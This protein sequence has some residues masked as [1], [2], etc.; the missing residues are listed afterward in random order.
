MIFDITAD[1]IARL[2]EYQLP[3]LLRILLVLECQRFKIP[4]SAVNVACSIKTPDGGVDGSVHW[5]GLPEKT[6]YLPHKYVVFQCK[7]QN[8]TSTQAGLEVEKHDHEG[9]KPEVDAALNEGAAYILFTKT[10]LTDQQ[11]KRKAIESIRNTF[12]RYE[13]SYKDTYIDVFDAAQI[14]TWT[15]QHFSAILTVREWIGR[16]PIDGFLPFQEWKKRRECCRR[17]SDFMIDSSLEK[18]MEE[19]AKR[20]ISPGESTRIVGLSGLGKTETV[21]QT[22]NRNLSNEYHY[23]L[24]YVDAAEVGAN[25]L[26]SRVRTLIGKNRGEWFGLIVDNCEPELHSRLHEI[27]SQSEG[28]LITI[29]TT[30]EKR[31]CDNTIIFPYASDEIIKQIITNRHPS[32]NSES[33]LRIVKFADGFPLIAVI[34]GEDIEKGTHDIGNLRDDNL[35]DKLLGN[36]TDEHKRSLQ[37]CAL[38]DCFGFSGDQAGQAKYIASEILSP[39]IAYE[40]FYRHIKDYE[41]RRL[42]DKRGDYRRVIPRPLAVSLAT[43]WWQRTSPG[44]IKEVIELLSTPEASTRL[45]EAFCRAMPQISFVKEA[46]DL[47]ETLCISPGPLSKKEGFESEWGSRL[48]LAFVEINPDATVDAIYSVTQKLTLEEIKK[49]ITF[50][51]RRNLV[52]ALEKLCFRKDCFEKAAWVLLRF[53]AAENENYANN[54]TGLFCQLFQV[55]LS[56]TETPPERR[57]AVI[58]RALREKDIRIKRIVIQAL[59]QVFEVDVSRGSGHE[60]Q[61]AS[62]ELIDWIPKLWGEIFSYYEKS[63]DYLVKIILEEPELAALAK[64]QIARNIRNILYYR[65]WDMLDKVLKRVIDHSGNYWP[66]ALS[67]IKKIKQFKAEE[68]PQ[69]MHDVLEEWESLLIP[70][71]LRQRIQSYVC[72]PPYENKK[73]PNGGYINIASINAEKFA[74]ECVV[75]KDE[76]IKDL[77]LLVQG[78]IRQGFVFGR[79]LALLLDDYHSI[80]NLLINEL[81]RVKPTEVNTSFIEGVLNG[82]QT[83]SMEDWK[84]YTDSIASNEKLAPFYVKIIHKSKFTH[85]QL[86]VIL[87]LFKIGKLSLINI[88]LLGCGKVLDQIESKYVAEFCLN[89][90]DISLEGKW[91]ALYLL[92]MFCFGNQDH[93]EDCE[94]SF[95][96]ILLEL[97]LNV[98]PEWFS[99]TDVWSS[100][101]NKLLGKNDNV[102]AEVLVK[103]IFDLCYNTHGEELS[104]QNCDVQL[105]LSTLVKCEYYKEILKHITE[106]LQS[107][108]SIA[109]LRLDFL[110]TSSRN[111]GQDRHLLMQFPKELLLKWANDNLDFAPEY[112]AKA[113][114]LYVSSPAGKI[115]IHPLVEDILNQFGDNEDVL[116]KLSSYAGC[117]T[118]WGGRS[119]ELEDEK[120]IYQLLAEH[121]NPTVRDWADTNIKSIERILDKEKKRNEE[122]EWGIY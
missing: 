7:A 70:Q 16:A 39:S 64:D 62:P 53:A 1:E 4:L 25:T 27:N 83:V 36:F 86:K 28:T 10:N 37:A 72:T 80:V 106:I 59:G 55:Y 115:S 114:P 60:I 101:V 108:N 42:I 118:F 52:R 41:K 5:E 104:V 87:D 102:F 69:E 14:A 63:L 15:N 57:I 38:F 74:T 117:K 93:W 68:M 116:G 79:K 111:K 97:D 48:F 13:K 31:V 26:I 12:I 99:D 24:I 91:V 78:E 22:C 109:I 46:V 73:G 33:V 34:L 75:N 95:H 82:I 98:I 58:E 120:S 30:V 92:Y 47:I 66:E 40:I 110:L 121:E 76:L 8:M 113:T 81:S 49:D 107:D 84:T 20:M 44:R 2:N 65:K 45:A 103:S 119:A 100:T 50:K 11:R 43:D 122:E 35:K 96:N 54:A 71:D 18:V 23:N 32:L 19:V 17:V 56:G 85:E 77:D 105:V 21:F 29:D 61:G 9:I 112:L 88:N 51:V 6:D 67:S 94:D 90:S 3:N 89:L